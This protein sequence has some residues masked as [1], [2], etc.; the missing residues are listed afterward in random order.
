LKIRFGICTFFP[1]I[2]PRGDSVIH[3]TLVHVSF[4][5]TTFSLKQLIALTIIG[6]FLVLGS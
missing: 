5:K 6:C 2:N 3:I 4:L 1:E